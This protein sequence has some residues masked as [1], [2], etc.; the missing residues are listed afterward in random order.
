MAGAVLAGNHQE[1]IRLCKAL[2]DENR[3]RMLKLLLD[4]DV[5]NCEMEVVFPGLSKSQ[6]SRDLT[7]LMN[8][9]CIQRRREGRCV[10]YSVDRVKCN[11]FS[12]SLLQVLDDSLNDDEV[13]RGDRERLQRAV[14]EGVRERAKKG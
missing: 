7:M 3:V 2:S 14:D 12:Q 8:V 4:Q 11:R 6:I 13:T 10:V 1:L 9:G 5:S